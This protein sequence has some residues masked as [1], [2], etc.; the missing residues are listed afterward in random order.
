MAENGMV[1]RS[2]S[3]YGGALIVEPEDASASDGPE[4]GRLR[5][6]RRERGYGAE[7]FVERGRRNYYDPALRTGPRTSGRVSS[8]PALAWSTLR[9]W[10]DV[11]V[12]SGESTHPDG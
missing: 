10:A 8:H 12:A 2:V 4:L 7:R 9:V 5:R 3:E 6:G 1:R 11:V